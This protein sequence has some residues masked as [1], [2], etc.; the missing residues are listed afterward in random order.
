MKSIA[1][2]EGWFYVERAVVIM[3]GLSTTLAPKLNTLQLGFPYIMKF[4]AERQRGAG[5]GAGVAQVAAGAAAGV[6][7][8]RRAERPVAAARHRGRRRGRGAGCRRGGRAA[9]AELLAGYSGRPI[10]RPT[11]PL[12]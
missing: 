5:R 3:F 12:G 10:R 6:V 1:Y 2:P 7:D 8:H 11:R 9:Q 4:I